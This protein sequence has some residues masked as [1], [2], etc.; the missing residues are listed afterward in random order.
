MALGYCEEFLI[1][2]FIVT[3]VLGFLPP[4]IAAFFHS[5][6]PVDKKVFGVP[7]S[8]NVRRTGQV[9]PTSILSAM[10]HLRQ[11]GTVGC[12]RH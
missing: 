9:L 8:V 1:T 3:K 2:V 4:L 11:A 5:L 7:L 12:H 10:D 6:L